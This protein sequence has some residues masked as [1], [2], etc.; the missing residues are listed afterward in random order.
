MLL[1]LYRAGFFLGRVLPLK[2][3]YVLAEIVGRIYFIFSDK[4]KDAL[5]KNLRVVLGPDIDDKEL[6]AHVLKVF[7]NFGK[8][9]ADFFKFQKVTKEQMDRDIEIEGQHHLDEAMTLN[10]GVILLSAHIGN[11]ELGGAAVAA[12]GYRINAIVLT[13]KDKK[14]NDLFSGRRSDYNVNGIPLGIRIKQCFKVLKD[15]QMLA[16]VVDKDYSGSNEC[17]EFFGREALMPKGAAAISLRTR[18]PI[19]VVTMTRKADD[20]FRLRFAKPI[21]YESSGDHAGD[22]K[23]LMRKYLE[24]VE[25]QILECPDQ[26]YVFEKIWKPQQTIQ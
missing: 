21:I 18:S 1:S 10:K 2:A 12:L 3:C 24:V 9:L 5:R 22:M 17:V 14:I 4:D 26:W 25:A 23:C 8:Y 15:N 16:I 13:H 6:D 19:V 11:W 7:I 20:T